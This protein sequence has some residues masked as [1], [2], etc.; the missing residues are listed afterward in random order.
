MA[1]TSQKVPFFDDSGRW[2]EILN[3]T[4]WKQYFLVSAISLLVEIIIGIRRKQFWEKAHLLMDNWFPVSGNHIFSPFFGDPCQFFFLSAGKIFFKEIVIF[5][6]WKQILELT[7]VSTSRKKVK[8]V[9]KRRQF[10]IDR[11]SD[12]TSQNEGL[13]NNIRFHY[14]KRLF[15]WQEY[16]KTPKKW[17]PTGER[18]LYKNEA[19]SFWIIVSTSTTFALNKRTL[20]R[21]SVS[22]RRNEAFDKKSVPTSWKNCFYC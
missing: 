15:H 12:S 19:T 22:T 18:L 5:G 2:S 16:L 1:K 6:Y 9:N 10:P 14:A 13:S 7:M 3:S 4:L 11:N 20:S 8:V 21:K 17:F